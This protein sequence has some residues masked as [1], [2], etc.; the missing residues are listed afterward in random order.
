MSMPNPWPVPPLC[1]RG[2]HTLCVD[3]DTVYFRFASRLRDEHGTCIYRFGPQ[4]DDAE[5]RTI[6]CYEEQGR[7]WICGTCGQPVVSFV[8]KSN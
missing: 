3:G 7:P 6:W 5:C 8:P 2:W 1:A 4:P